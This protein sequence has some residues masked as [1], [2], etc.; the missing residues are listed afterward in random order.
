MEDSK[1]GQPAPYCRRAMVTTLHSN[2]VLFLRLPDSIE[3]VAYSADRRIDRVRAALPKDDV[4]Q[5]WGSEL[6]QTI[7]QLDCRLASEA[8]VSGCIWQS[9]EL[10]SGRLNNRLLAVTRI[11]T[12]KPRKGVLNPVTVHIHEMDPLGTLPGAYALRLVIQQ[13][14]DRVNPVLIFFLETIHTTSQQN[15]HEE[16]ARPPSTTGKASS[17]PSC[18]D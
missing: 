14:R 10:L 9:F 18:L 5:S 6:C 15:M 13:G 7:G 3:V 1:R 11:D 2:E 4:V 17:R 8:K 12:P 16:L